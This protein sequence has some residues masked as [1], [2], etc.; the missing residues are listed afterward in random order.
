[1]IAITISSSTR[2]KP[3]R[4]KDLAREWNTAM[5]PRTSRHDGRRTDVASYS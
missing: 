4:G 3:G 5:S 1:M 2:V